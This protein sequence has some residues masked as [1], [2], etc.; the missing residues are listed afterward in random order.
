MIHQ[1]PTPRTIG[2]VNWLGLWTLYRKEVRRFLKVIFQTVGAP[3]VTTLLFFAVFALALGGIV[4]QHAADDAVDDGR[5]GRAV[6][7]RRGGECQRA[8]HAKNEEHHGF[9]HRH[10]SAAH[11]I[12]VQ[13]RTGRVARRGI[14]CPAA[15]PAG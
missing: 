2:A 15:G 1:A 9:P 5:A 12:R 7:L 3:V 10:T 14:P 6:L 4:R 8:G 13:A 11:A